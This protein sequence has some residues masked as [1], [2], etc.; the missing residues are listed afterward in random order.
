[1]PYGQ[2]KALLNEMEP[3]LLRTVAERLNVRRSISLEIVIEDLLKLEAETTLK[4]I[5]QIE[6]DVKGSGR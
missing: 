1:M 2:L 4:E 5:A 3:G 6:E